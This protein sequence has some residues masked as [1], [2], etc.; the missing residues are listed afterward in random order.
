MGVDLRRLLKDPQLTCFISETVQTPRDYLGYEENSL[1]LGMDMARAR[2]R[3][4]DYG[5]LLHYCECWG[6]AGDLRTPRAGIMDDVEEDLR[7]QMIHQYRPSLL[8]FYSVPLVL[9][10]EGAWYDQTAAGRFWERLDEYRRSWTI[11]P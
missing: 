5:F 9:V 11:R 8:S 3:T 2:G 10:K 7:W 1:S 4:G 6:Q